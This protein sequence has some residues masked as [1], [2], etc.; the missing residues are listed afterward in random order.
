MV[1][2]GLVNSQEEI[3]IIP[4]SKETLLDSITENH[5]VD[6]G[7]NSAGAYLTNGDVI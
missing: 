1:N 7:L 2:G 6:V 4:N 5:Y 3:Q